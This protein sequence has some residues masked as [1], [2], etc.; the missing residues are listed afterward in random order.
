MVFD[1]IANANRLIF[2][3][4]QSN[5][6]NEKSRRSLYKNLLFVKRRDSNA[7]KNTEI[8]TINKCRTY[9]TVRKILLTS[10]DFQGF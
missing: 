8:G 5:L 2:F 7:V 1:T 6:F 3:R 9:L 10:T 4:S